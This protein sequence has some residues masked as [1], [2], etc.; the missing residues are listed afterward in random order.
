MIVDRPISIFEAFDRAKKG[1]KMPEK[2][3]DFKVIPQSAARLKK[4]YSLKFKER[5][6]PYREANYKQ[7]VSSGF[8]NAH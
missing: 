8:S 5:D 1:V 7:S 4:E 3:W 2:E 6:N